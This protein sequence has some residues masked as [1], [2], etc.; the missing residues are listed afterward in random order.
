MPQFTLAKYYQGVIELCAVCASKRDPNNAALH[1]YSAN[2]P[3]EDQEGLAAYTLRTKYYREVKLMLDH[4]FK[5]FNSEEQPPQSIFSFRS[6]NQQSPS[7][8]QNNLNETVLH[9]ITLALQIPD[10]LLHFVVYEWLLSHNLLTELLNISEPSLGIY[11]VRSVQKSPDNVQLADIL[12]KYYER[13]GQHAAATKIL[14]ELAT[15]PN[16]RLNLGERIEYLARA[17]MCMRSDPA[18][19]SVTNGVLLK[20]I[21]D[22]VC[23]FVI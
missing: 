14:D 10:Q 15:L 5:S 17:V 6:T 19:Y 3:M 1:Y 16:N 20:N 4:I 8:P 9:A 18:G 12:W 23:I 21:E 11:L 7:A 2:E 13:N 22:K